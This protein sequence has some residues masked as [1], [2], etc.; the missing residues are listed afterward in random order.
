MR[1]TLVPFGG[2]PSEILHPS[3]LGIEPSQNK[4]RNVS[5]QNKYLNDGNVTLKLVYLFVNWSSIIAKGAKQ[6]SSQTTCACHHVPSEIN[7]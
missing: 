3:L 6:P 4:L 5:K 2:Q 7:R 1:I